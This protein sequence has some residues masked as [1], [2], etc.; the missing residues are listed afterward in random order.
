MDT[1]VVTGPAAHD[2]EAEI[3]EVMTNSMI[4]RDGA[5]TGMIGR[6][7]GLATTTT[8]TGIMSATEAVMTDT[9]ATGPD[10]GTEAADT[11]TGKTEEEREVLIRETADAELPANNKDFIRRCLKQVFFCAVSLF[12]SL[13]FHFTLVSRAADGLRRVQ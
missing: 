8:K 10:R 7:V 1:A 4:T 5:V 9:E 6:R 3:E 11:L 2:V 13:V 12:S